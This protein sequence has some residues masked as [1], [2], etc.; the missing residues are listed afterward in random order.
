MF[1]CLLISSIAFVS[2]LHCLFVAFERRL[3]KMRMIENGDERDPCEPQ[4]A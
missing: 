3:E 4:A 1:V 2:F